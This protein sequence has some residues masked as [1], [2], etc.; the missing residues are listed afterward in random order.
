MSNDSNVIEVGGKKVGRIISTVI[1]VLVLVIIA[2]NAF[3]TVDAG[4][5]GVVKT[6]GKVSET[7]RWLAPPLQRIFRMC[8]APL[9]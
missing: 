9:R 6:F 3:T 8:P 2:A 1:V 5:S 4:H 7:V